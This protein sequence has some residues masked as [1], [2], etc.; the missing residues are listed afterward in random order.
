MY[1][2]YVKDKFYANIIII[3]NNTKLNYKVLFE[4]DFSHV[5]TKFYG[6]ITY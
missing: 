5:Y 2:F 4:I 6:K 1:Y 3:I